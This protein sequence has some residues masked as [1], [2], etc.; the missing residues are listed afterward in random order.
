MSCKQ[1]SF[2]TIFLALVSI[3]SSASA[4]YTAAVKYYDRVRAVQISVD[5]AGDRG[6]QTEI[7][8]E[9]FEA[10]D[11]IID[12]L[13]DTGRDVGAPFR[14][15]IRKNVDVVRSQATRTRDYARTWQQKLERRENAWDACVAVQEDLQDL[16]AAWGGLLGE[17]MMVRKELETGLQDAART[18]QEGYR[19]YLELT[20]AESDAEKKTGEAVAKLRQSVREVEEAENQLSNM[21]ATFDEAVEKF[22]EAMEQGTTG[23][24]NEKKLLQIVRSLHDRRDDAQAKL[25]YREKAN[26][27][28]YKEYCSLAAEW[29]K[30]QLALRE[31]LARQDDINRI[32]ETSN[33]FLDWSRQFATEFPKG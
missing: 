33:N 8:K 13:S 7:A 31:Y 6:R 19:R 21:E 16:G 4:Q 20:K 28:R 25:R 18:R 17:I 23:A 32:I 9:I 22:T 3:T 15:R 5:P 29:D 27:E 24:E 14:D 2:A 11:E 10:T 1:K 12:T 30:A 26:D